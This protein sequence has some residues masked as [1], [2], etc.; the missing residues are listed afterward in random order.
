[1][2]WIDNLVPASFREVPFEVDSSEFT[3]GRRVANHQFP[4]RKFPYA[5]DTGKLSD[6]YNLEAFVLGDDYMQKRDA[7]IEAFQTEGS[8]KLIHPFYGEKLV[9]C[10]PVSVKETLSK[11]GRIA[12][13]TLTFFE[14][15]DN[16]FPSSQED[17]ESTL[18]A[19]TAES[20][21]QAKADF[22]E[23]FSVAQLPGF[24]VESARLSV[25][26]ALDAFDDATKDIV[27]LADEAAELAFSLRSLKS[28]IT[29]LMNAPSK[30]ADRLMDSLGL[31][32]SVSF[33]SGEAVKAFQ[34]VMVFVPPSFSPVSVVT[35]TRTQ[36]AQNI[37]AVEKLVQ[38]GAILNGCE[39]SI[40]AEYTSSNEA[41]EVRESFT[42]QLDIQLTDTGND[43]IFQVLQDVKAAMV[44][45]VPDPDLDL[46]GIQTVTTEGNISSIVLAYDLFE[47]LD[48]EQ[49]LIDR[50]SIKHPGFIPANTSLEVVDV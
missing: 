21:V 28:E 49:D 5:E 6:G 33:S 45:S 16:R 27:T 15:G 22:V 26:D 30:L 50:N 44:R 3:T 47:S 19:F 1:M 42:D 13:F 31:L 48:G 43:L 8:G 37:S 24:A 36:E 23:K 35:P 14:A 20:F 32:T 10:G 34:S 46:A 2:G 12:K 11:D 4:D 9:Q 18:I 40:D 39:Q 29:E 17:K 41:V 7:L 38:R 25:S